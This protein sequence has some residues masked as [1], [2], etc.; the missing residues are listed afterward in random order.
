[1][2]VTHEAGPSILAGVRVTLCNGDL[3]VATSPVVA[4]YTDVVSYL[5]LWETHTQHSVNVA[6]LLVSVIES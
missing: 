1:M 6:P 3:T 5:I 2:Y 4:T